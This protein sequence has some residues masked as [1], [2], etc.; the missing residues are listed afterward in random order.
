[1]NT[2][3]EGEDLLIELFQLRE[4]IAFYGDSTED[5]HIHSEKEEGE[6]GMEAIILIQKAENT[7]SLHRR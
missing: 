3:L 7:C 1:M 4:C 2:Q 6:R 5:R